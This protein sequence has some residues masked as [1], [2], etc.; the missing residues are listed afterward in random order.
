MASAT[1]SSSP[2]DQADSSNRPNGPDPVIRQGTVDGTRAPL[3]CRRHTGLY[4][5][6][7]CEAASLDR[8]RF[9]AL[10]ILLGTICPLA[11]VGAPDD[12]VEAPHTNI[13]KLLLSEYK[14]APPK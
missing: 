6:C 12:Q 7:A 9:A 8:M 10:L 1:D 14:Y 11:A 5:T 4:E 13:R 2:L 3:R